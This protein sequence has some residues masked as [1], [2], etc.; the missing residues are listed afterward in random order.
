MLE[1]NQRLRNTS[2]KP[3]E[4]ECEKSHTLAPVGFL[5]IILYDCKG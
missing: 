2:E 1:Q 5:H 3:T 4:T